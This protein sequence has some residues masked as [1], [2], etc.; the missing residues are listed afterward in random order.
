MNLG[1]KIL[2]VGANGSGKTTFADK[3][4]KRLNIK[5]YELDSIFWKPD[6]QE[7]ENAEFRAK[8]DE[9]TKKDEWVIDGNY[10]RNQDLTISRADTIIWLDVPYTKML[11]RVTKRSLYRVLSQKPLWHNNRES[12]GSLFSRKSIVLFA[13][14]TYGSKNAKYNRLISGSE[15]PGKKWIRIKSKREEIIFWR[16]LIHPMT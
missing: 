14:K 3:L 2:V 10:S 5:H 12:L 4:S 15:Y 16:N 11:Y 9:V 6:W 1:K 8:V 7:S 13:S